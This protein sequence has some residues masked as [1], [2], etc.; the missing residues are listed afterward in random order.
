MPS[1]FELP[2]RSVDTLERAEARNRAHEIQWTKVC[3]EGEVKPTSQRRFVEY[4]WKTRWHTT[5]A[6]VQRLQA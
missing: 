2:G 1:N 5:K 3:L 6:R 4:K